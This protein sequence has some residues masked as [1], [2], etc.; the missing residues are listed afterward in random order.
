MRSLMLATLAGLV[1]LSMAS[2]LQAQR[3]GRS[4]LPVAIELTEHLAN[5]MEAF[6]YEAANFF[7]NKKELEEVEE[8]LKDVARDVEKLLAAIDKAYR[9]P[10]KLDKLHDRAEDLE[11]EIGELA[12]EVRKQI[13]RQNLQWNRERFHLN[14]HARSHGPAVRVVVVG[15]GPELAP[16]H[17]GDRVVQPAYPGWH[18]E[19]RVATMQ[20]I[21]RELHRLTHRL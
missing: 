9:R 17:P 13:R 7:T 8:E 6:R 2:P 19:A 21:A 3:H 5:E 14:R 12:E 18:L 1:S 11:E 15:A 10:S 20:Q 4:A 16:A